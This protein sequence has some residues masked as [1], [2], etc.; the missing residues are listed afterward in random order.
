MQ[1][2]TLLAHFSNQERDRILW[3]SLNSHASQHSLE[4]LRY[5]R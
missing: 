1:L 5:G 2:A 4:H 3:K